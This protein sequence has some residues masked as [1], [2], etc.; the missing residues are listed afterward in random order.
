M[1][2]NS[3]P[4]S[5]CTYGLR[6][7]YFGPLYS[8]Q[9]NLPVA[10]FGAGSARYTG[11]TVNGGG[12][13]WN[14]QKGNVG[15][16]FGFN[17]SPNAVHSN[18]VVRGGYGLNFNQDEIAITA[19]AANNPPAQNNIN[20]A[21]TTPANAGVNGANILYGISSSPTSL[22]GFVSNPHAITSYNA[23]GLPTAGNASV[24]IVG[25]GYRNLPTT[26]TEHY[27]LD[28]EYQFGKVL[29]ASL[30][31]Q[32]S[33][34]RH[35]INHENPNAPGAVS[36]VALNSLIT[37]GDLWVNEGSSNNNAFLAEAKHNTRQLSLDAQFM[38]S[39]SMDTDGS[40]PYYEDPYFPANAAY[41]YGRS[42]FNVGK[43]VK[44]FGLYQPIFFH[45]EHRWAE[46]IAGGWSLSG[47]FQYHTGFP[48]SPN[49]GISQSLYCSQ[50]G[51]QNV[52]PVYLGG[53]GNDHSN[54]AFIKGSNFA[55][56]TTGAVAPTATVNG[57]ANTTVAYSN[58]YFNVPNFQNLITATNGTG[59]P[60]P[61]L[62][63][64]G[65]PGS[66]RNSFDGPNYRNIDASLTKAFG[67]PNNRLL[68]E[69]ARFEVRA[70]VFN[71]FNILNLNPQSVANNINATNF[72][73][74]TT[75]LGGRTITFQG[76]FSF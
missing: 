64:P 39:K 7:S 15:P 32:G 36:G 56:L 75:A 37:G 19:N 57:T 12:N 17:W 20:Y 21:F 48:F 47:I 76:R 72:G 49:Y 5:P 22:V 29:I 1:T 74:D 34:G 10:Q 40:G 28:T 63:I 65:A 46:K 33:V 67:I 16:Q 59:F 6:Y 61:N 52:R 41:S 14:P 2:G 60:S 25:D 42:D 13:L 58:R 55:G 27:S 50:C 73:Q 30:G 66:A 18:L 26:Y 24:V 3:S 54:N 70:D 9:N 31:Y 8:K 62:A 11:L 35:L 68:G 38:W 45:G 44:I 69:S 71:L 43:S 4:T 53:A 23:A 51:Y